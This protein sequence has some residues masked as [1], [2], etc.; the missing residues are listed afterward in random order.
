MKKIHPFLF[1]LINSNILVALCVL[2]LT[3][4]TEILFETSNYKI[5]QFVFFST[6]FTY[7]F[8]RISRIKNNYNHIK[9]KW[10]EDNR[11]TVFIIM[12]IGI[13]MSLYRFLDFKSTTQVAIIFTGIVSILYSYGLRRIPYAKLFIISLIW[14]IST[15]YLL[16]LEN[17]IPFTYNLIL[18]LLTR[19]L[20][21]I[22]ITIP[23]DIRDIPFDKRELKTIPTRFGIY[24]SKIISII[25]LFL[26]EI[27][28]ILQC[29]NFN[30]SSKIVGITC[31][32][33]IASTLI[34]KTS[35][36]KTD[37]Y[38][39][40]W[41]ESLSILFYLFLSLSVLMF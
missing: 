22:A 24:K 30:L 18:N 12:I 32:Y 40:F 2:S 8:Q 36:D 3:V 10:L 5:S 37:F 16:I 31:T 11:I 26:A 9:K 14:T 20:F 39:S 6:L 25:T 33:L 15:M 38:F 7:N 21:V 23:F 29:I 35:K 13:V 19:F 27:L 41:I 1:Y 28:H 34:I 4:S 17:D